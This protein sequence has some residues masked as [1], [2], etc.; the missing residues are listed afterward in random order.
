MARKLLQW[1]E[2][3]SLAALPVNMRVRLLGNPMPLSRDGSVK[4]LV[5]VI[6]RSDGKVKLIRISRK[7]ATII[8]DW[9]ALTG[10]N[11][12]GKMGPDF[13]ISAGDAKALLPTPFTDEE[14]EKIKIGINIPFIEEPN[15]EV[16]DRAC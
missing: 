6:D 2:W 11:P 3:K 16:S 14:K 12:G 1:V 10:V 8:G 15:R 9:A 4:Y 13:I 7:V 5:N